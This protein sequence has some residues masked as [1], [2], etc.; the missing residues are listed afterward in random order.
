[1]LRDLDKKLPMAKNFRY[2]EFIKSATARRNGIIL[3][4]NEHE[5]QSIERTANIILQ[6]VREKFGPI[7][8]TSG[9]R[10]VELC[11][12]VGSSPN[13]NHVR[14]EA[15]DFEPLK[16]GVR[17][18]DIVKWIHDN[19]MYREL[20]AEYFPDGWIHAAYRFNG[21]VRKLK[22]KDPTHSYS[23]VTMSDLFY[24]YN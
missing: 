8:I 14:G 1:M 4:P 5:W 10:S 11:K 16:H 9:Y 21:N 18:I 7:R 2:H 22:L 17:M 12:L 23:R 19:L 6:P 20:I 13:S 3:D 24:L 15:V